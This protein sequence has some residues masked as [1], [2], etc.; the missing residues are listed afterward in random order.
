MWILWNVSLMRTETHLKQYCDIHVTSIWWQNNW[1]RLLWIRVWS[2]TWILTLNYEQR[3]NLQSLY[4][5]NLLTNKTHSTKSNSVFLHNCKESDSFQATPTPL[6]SPQSI[7]ITLRYQ[8]IS[9]NMVSQL[10]FP[11]NAGTDVLDDLH[12]QK[13]T[14]ENLLHLTSEISGLKCQGRP[15][16]GS[17]DTNDKVRYSSGTGHKFWF[18]D[19]N[20]TKIVAK[21][22]GML[23]R[24]VQ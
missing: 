3:Q 12:K 22:C 4:C 10:P 9:L 13:N 19:T 2:C 8:P 14:P 18:K 21:L 11:Q 20:P 7:C 1:H 5:L 16:N 17:R 23:C 15:S 24:N 6:M